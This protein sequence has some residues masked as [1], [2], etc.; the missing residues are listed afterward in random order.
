MH[1]QVKLYKSAYCVDCS[2]GK[3]DASTFFHA[4]GYVMTYACTVS[5][6]YV[7]IFYLDA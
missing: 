7:I 1:E 6:S 2:L 3:K 5:G 4:V